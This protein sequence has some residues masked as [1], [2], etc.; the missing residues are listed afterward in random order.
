MAL[1]TRK[2]RERQESLW[3]AKQELPASAAHPFY[4]RLNELLESE[5][6]DEFAESACQQYYAEKMGR[7]GLTPGI[8]FR[9]LLVGYFEGIDSERGI[10]WRAADSL[11]IRHFLGIGLD[12]RSPDHSTISRTRRLIA[13]ET[14]EE[15]F[16]FVLRVL[17][18]RGL[19]KGQTVGVDATTLE[20]NAAMRSIVRR[21]S[22]ESYQEFL[23]GLAKESGIET[24]T[25]E[26]LAK[27]DRKRK[28]R[29]SNQDWEHPQDPDAKITKMK[30]GSTHLAHKA[31]HAVDL[32]T[33]A[34]ITVTVQGADEGDT[35]TITE[36]VA[37]AGEWIAETAEAVN[38]ETGGERVNPEGPAEVVADKGYHSNAVLLKL[39]ESGV[40]SY[41]PEPDRGERNWV[42]KA[43]EKKAVYGNRRRMQGAHGKRLMKRRGE[44]IERSFAHMY[45]TGAMRRTHLRGRDNIRKRL[46]I[47]A[48]AFNLSLVFRELFQVGTPRGLQGRK[49]TV[50]SAIC[51]V[52]AALT[53]LVADLPAARRTQEILHA[54]KYFLGPRRVKWAACAGNLKMPTLATGC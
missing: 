40:R 25:R 21:D 22:G 31:E 51:G 7:P 48:S 47:H 9:C 34:I 53:A 33:G 54:E 19:M 13:V 42:G 44:Y 11:G 16:G 20:A 46:L 50:F 43:A 12:E 10:A 37:E 45:E 8:Y 1:G 26:Q 6:F 41:I 18:T 2:Q 32:E 38:G 35:A 17:A 5:K 4:A 30:D 24:P 29:M 52:L 28:K 49:C 14:H 39:S 27:L 15:V 36:T 23:T 3:I